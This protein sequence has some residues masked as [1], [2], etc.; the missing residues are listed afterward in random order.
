MWQESFGRGQIILVPDP[1]LENRVA[2]VVESVPEKKLLDQVNQFNKNQNKSEC[3]S[4]VYKV[5]KLPR[6]LLGKINRKEMLSLL[7]I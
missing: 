3:I 1:R 4:V 6:T 7:G 5:E 2:L